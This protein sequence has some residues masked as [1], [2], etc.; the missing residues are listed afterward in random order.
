MTGRPLISTPDTKRSFGIDTSQLA[1]GRQASS[2]EDGPAA[3]EEGVGLKLSEKEHGRITKLMQKAVETSQSGEPFQLAGKIN[4]SRITHTI[5]VSCTRGVGEDAADGTATREFRMDI[6]C[7]NGQHTA[8]ILRLQRDKNGS[9]WLNLRANPSSLINGYNALGVALNGMSPNDE[10][11]RLLRTPFEVLRRLLR[12]VDPKFEWEPETK[13]RIKKLLFKA[14]PVQVFTYMATAPFALDQWL[15]YLR[16][17]LSCPLGNGDGGYCLLADLLGIELDS[18]A[19]GGPVQGL[20][21]RFMKHGRV[22]LSVNLYDKIAAARVDAAKTNSEVGDAKV[23][24]FLS[25]HVRVD[26]TLHDAVLRELMAEAK[27]GSKDTV[28]LTA[29]MFN[30]AVGVLNRGKGKSGQKFVPWLLNYI[31]DDRLPLLSL[32]QYRPGLVDKVRV[33]LADYNAD[34]AAVFDEWRKLGFRFV[35]D[36]AVGGSDPTSGVTF[37]QFATRWARVMVKR[38]VARTI[39]NKAREAG[40]DLDIPL[41]AYDGLFALTH[42]FDLAPDDRRAFAVALEKGDQKVVWRL[43]QRSRGNSKVT[44]GKVH[45]TLMKMI[46]GAHVPA[47]KVGEAVE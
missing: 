31:F 22:E 35:P 16:A 29:D 13:A 25:K 28:L 17:V 15:G 1:I 44:I 11:G 30:R 10:R 45:Q 38:Q 24:D 7:A 26:A 6:K 18:R 36:A 14:C 5:R 37:E 12:E 27:L 19:R 20:L 46:A 42:F 39:S 40:L 23:R 47:T 34:A 41:A 2:S 9:F 8:I 43:M 3:S 21:L 4:G 33:D 32:L